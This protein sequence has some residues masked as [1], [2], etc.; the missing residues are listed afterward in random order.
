MYIEQSGT[1]LTFLYSQALSDRICNGQ[2]EKG[3]H[4]SNDPQ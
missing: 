2:M 4:T 1:V 3:K